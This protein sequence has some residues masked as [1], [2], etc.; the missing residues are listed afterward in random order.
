MNIV[1]IF[2]DDGAGDKGGYYL[3]TPEG[4]VELKVMSNQK[5]LKFPKGTKIIPQRMNHHGDLIDDA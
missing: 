1:K 3:E 4:Y 2:W 5:Y